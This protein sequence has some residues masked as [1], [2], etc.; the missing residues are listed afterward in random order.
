MKNSLVFL[1]H[2]DSPHRLI[3]PD[4]IFCTA[5][6]THT[7]LPAEPVVVKPDLFPTYHLA[8]VVDGQSMGITLVLPHQACPSTTHQH[9][10]VA[11][12]YTKLAKPH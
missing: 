6:G 10:F 9:Q 7:S 11:D 2:S 5:Q 3:R 12:E 8:S 1:N 4:L